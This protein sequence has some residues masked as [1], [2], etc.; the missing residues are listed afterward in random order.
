MKHSPARMEGSIVPRTAAKLD[1]KLSQSKSHTSSRLVGT[2]N[3]P[4]MRKRALIC[5]SK[6]IHGGGYENCSFRVK[7]KLLKKALQ[8]VVLAFF[9]T[10]LLFSAALAK[11]VR[12]G[13]VSSGAFPLFIAQ[14]RGLFKKYGLDTEVITFQGNPL[15]VQSLVAG[16]LQFI[17]AGGNSLVD[18][19]VAGADVVTIGVYI[20]TLPY[21]LVASEKIKSASQ[22]KGRRLA[23]SRLGAA[24]DIGLR[25]VLQKLGIDPKETII[26]GIGGTAE[27]FAA[28]KAGSVDAT[29]ITPPL[30]ITAR[31]LGFN[32]IASFQNAGIKWAFNSIDT[33]AR[34]A[35]NNRETVLNILK[36]IID[37]IAYIH[38]NKEET[39]RILSKQYLLTDRGTLEELYTYVL[40]VVQ[41]KPFS[42]EEG[43]QMMIDSASMTNPKA[44]EFKPQDIVDMQ[45]LRE[46][47]QSG[48]LDKIYK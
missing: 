30:T 32:E 20:D 37:G 48:F 28:L 42:S 10:G 35:K 34:Y 23:V 45:Y 1:I 29:V 9:V 22:L 25:M 33:T 46:L 3:L 4:S 16:E 40:K 47:E 13:S 19:K 12:I 15:M 41:K 31:K 2:E 36:G 21:T 39:I 43:I 44:R 18:A 11:S 17:D 6:Q 27:R 5:S 14:E 26:L 38:K 7:F 8:I 24:S